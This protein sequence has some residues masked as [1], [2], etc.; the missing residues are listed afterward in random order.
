MLKLSP[1]EKQLLARIAD[2]NTDSNFSL[3]SLFNE[4]L[5]FNYDIH[6]TYVF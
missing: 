1:E 4:I 3:R 2:G 6:A 5:Q